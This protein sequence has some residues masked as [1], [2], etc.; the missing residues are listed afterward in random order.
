MVKL[1]LTEE[2]AEMLEAYL[3]HKQ[4]NLENANL[5][6]SKCYPLICGIRKKLKKD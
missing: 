3:F 5:K 1:E 6:D 4:I 2:E